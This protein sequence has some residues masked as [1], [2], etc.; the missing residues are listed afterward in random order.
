MS[1]VFPVVTDRYGASAIAALI[2]DY[3]QDIG[4]PSHGAEP[5]RSSCVVRLLTAI[6]A[7]STT[8]VQAEIM[9]LQGNTWV[10]TGQLLPGGVRSAT[11]LAV[12]T[13]GRRIARRCSRFGWVVVET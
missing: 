7:G 5:D 1:E 2:S 9:Q 13:T 6:S 11:G 8:P 12:T 4:S 3:G 10:G